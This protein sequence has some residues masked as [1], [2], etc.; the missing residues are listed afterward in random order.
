MKLDLS[1]RRLA[2]PIMTHPG[3][4]LIGRKVIDAVKSGDVHAEAIIRLSEAMPSDAATVIMDLTV[5]AEAFGASVSFP[6]N[7]VPS[8]AG[9]QAIKEYRRR[10]SS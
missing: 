9:R 7:E 3:I 2:I 4:E 10:E 1:K 6:D 8:V 5:E